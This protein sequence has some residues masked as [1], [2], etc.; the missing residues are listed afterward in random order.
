LNYGKD[1]ANDNN[2]NDNFNDGEA[3]QGGICFFVHGDSIANWLWLV[4]SL[5]A[6][7]LGIGYA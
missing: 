5:L 3:T 7:L 4:T 2:H 1:K 6:C